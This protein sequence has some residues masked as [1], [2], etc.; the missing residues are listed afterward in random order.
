MQSDYFQQ[1][2]GVVL[3]HSEAA[4]L[5]SAGHKVL[6]EEERLGDNQEGWTALFQPRPGLSAL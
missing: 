3:C 5:N 1:E 4:R 2:L 6:L